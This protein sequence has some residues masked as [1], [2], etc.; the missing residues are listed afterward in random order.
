MIDKV[1]GNEYQLLEELGHGAY[2]CLFLAQSLSTNTYVAVKVLSKAGLDPQQL[3]LQQL[4][5]DIQSS[6]KHPSL[7]AL[8]RVLEDEDYIFM[9]M[10]LCDQGDLF[11]FVIRDQEVN[12]YREEHLVKQAYMQILEGVEYMHAQNIYHR[13]IK[14]ENILLKCD[15]DDEDTSA[16]TCKVADFGLATRDKYSMEFGC[17]STT[18]LAPEHFDG[19]DSMVQ[20]DGELGPYDSSASDVWSLGILLIALMFGRNPWQEATTMDPA[21]AEF[22]RHPTMLKQ[23][24]FPA[25]SASAYRF[26]KSVLAVDANK[27][28]TVAEMKKQF[29]ALDNLYSDEEDDDEEPLTPVDIPNVTKQEN[30]ASCDSAFFSGV[31]HVG[32]SSWSDMVEEEEAK[33]GPLCYRRESHESHKMLENHDDD[34]T[35]FIHSEEKESWWL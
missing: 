27:R 24:L 5:I 29:A 34:D 7:L 1:I 10:E 11:D 26:I 3:Q 4:E 19:D 20:P 25:L 32:P 8:H 15:E 12:K 31:T 21:F 16:I 17:G 2:G 23:Q 30:H 9:V 14:L 6:L 13:D 28:P 18:Y 35:M 22:K 33:Y